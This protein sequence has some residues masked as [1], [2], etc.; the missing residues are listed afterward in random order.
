MKNSIK[1]NVS[2]DDF[3]FL[4]E[5]AENKNNVFNSQTLLKLLSAYDEMKVSFLSEMPLELV[6]I[7]VAQE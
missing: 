4:L 6:L 3:D 2:E 5:I 7:D 1:N